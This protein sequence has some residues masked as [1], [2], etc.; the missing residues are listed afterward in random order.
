MT[1]SL[2]D[3]CKFLHIYKIISDHSVKEISIETCSKNSNITSKDKL[4]LPVIT[5]CNI[6]NFSV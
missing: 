2:C 4:S 1:K 6:F 5:E 3:D